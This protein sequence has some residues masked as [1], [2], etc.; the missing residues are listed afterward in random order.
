MRELY[1]VGLVMLAFAPFYL[2]QKRSEVLKFQVNMGK[3][4]HFDLDNC[5]HNLDLA[6]ILPKVFCVTRQLLA[7]NAKKERGQNI[8]I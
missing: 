8:E 6:P 1:S 3:S 7:N 5:F 2:V 4:E